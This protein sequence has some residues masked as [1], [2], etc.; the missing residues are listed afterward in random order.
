MATEALVDMVRSYAAGFIFTTSLPPTV[1]AGSMEVSQ[2][3][4]RFQL[5][6]HFNTMLILKRS[7]MEIDDPR[8]ALGRRA[9]TAQ[10]ASIQREL[11]ATE[12]AASRNFRRAHTISHHPRFC[13]SAT[14]I[15]AFC[16]GQ[17][18]LSTDSSCG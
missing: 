7:E 8:S 9:P 6:I 16:F 12:A 4:F 14:L 18:P 5:S 1:L 11:P 10:T 3:L 13:K 17:F 2:R 15:G